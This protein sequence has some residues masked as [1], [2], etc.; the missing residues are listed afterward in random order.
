M[1]ARHRLQHLHHLVGR[2][3]VVDAHGQVDPAAPVAERPVDHALG[4][5]LRVG[6]D[7]LGAE[8]G[9]HDAGAD[10][11]PRHFPDE[12]A[13]LD[14][15]TDVDRTLEQEVDPQDEVVHDALHA[16]AEADAKAPA[17]APSSW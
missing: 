9:P 13:D 7:D 12:I 16:E 14:D 6:D 11:D 2:A 10:P 1:T 8:V 3:P 17:A 5:Q 4:G 15:V